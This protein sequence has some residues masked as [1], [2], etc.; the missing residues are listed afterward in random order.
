MDPSE[1]DGRGGRDG[2]DRRAG[3]GLCADE[4]TP[5]PIDLLGISPA[6]PVETKATYSN[7]NQYR[8]LKLWKALTWCSFK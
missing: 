8:T 3:K 4:S 2:R 5:I 7:S 6:F 1:R